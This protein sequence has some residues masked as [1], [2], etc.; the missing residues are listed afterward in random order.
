M[1][2]HMETFR[3]QRIWIEW[4]FRWPRAYETKITSEFGPKVIGRGPAREVLEKVAK[5][6][7]NEELRKRRKAGL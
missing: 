4:L 6:R 7:W 2:Q 3:V 5:Q 1:A